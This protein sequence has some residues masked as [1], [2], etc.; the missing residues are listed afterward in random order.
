MLEARPPTAV[1]RVLEP[2]VDV[3]KALLAPLEVTV[4]KLALVVK[5]EL[6]ALPEPLEPPAIPVLL[7]ESPEEGVGD[8]AI[9]LGAPV[10]AETPAEAQMEVP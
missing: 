8:A 1:K 3:V 7:P 10:V 9:A 5:A 4:V 6:D 2:T